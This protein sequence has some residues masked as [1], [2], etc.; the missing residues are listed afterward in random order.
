M[1][2]WYKVNTYAKNVREVQVVRE[3][4]DSIA[5]VHREDDPKGRMVLKKSY[6][7]T[8]FPDYDTAYNLLLNIA[9]RA[10]EN[11]EDNLKR[12]KDRFE[13]VKRSKVV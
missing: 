10:V 12:A 7:T 2:I 9:K 11:A 6:D 5:I 1:K 8:Y 13:A 4:E 3:T